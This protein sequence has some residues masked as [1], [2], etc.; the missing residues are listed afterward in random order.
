MEKHNIKAKKLA[1]YLHVDVDSVY[2]WQNGK[3]NMNP[4]ILKKISEYL[5]VTIDEILGNQVKEE[6]DI[7]IVNGSKYKVIKA[8]EAS[9]L[10]D[11]AVY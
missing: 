4:T 8:V 9:G 1:E 5:N 2:N 11:D 6:S 7:Y 3:R 10:T